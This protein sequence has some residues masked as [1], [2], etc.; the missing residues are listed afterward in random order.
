MLDLPRPYLLFLGDTSERGYVKTALGLRDWAP[1]HCV[2]ECGLPGGVSIDLPRF[3]PSE[4]KA[5]G[6]RSLVVGVANPGGVIP[7]C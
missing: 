7:D 1:E 2:G 4:A 5:A 3:T 6:A